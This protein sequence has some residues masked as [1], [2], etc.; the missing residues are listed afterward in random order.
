MSVA[1]PPGCASKLSEYQ[2]DVRNLLLVKNANKRKKLLHKGRLAIIDFLAQF[3]PQTKH[4]LNSFSLDVPFA[5]PQA[6]NSGQR[7]L[8]GPITIAGV[9][10]QSSIKPKE[11]QQTTEAAS[12]DTFRHFNRSII[13]VPKGNGFVIVNDILLVTIPTQHQIKVSCQI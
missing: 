7:G 12:E 10:S 13:L 8:I 5:A 3:F 2:G 6:A 4:N 9:F 1:F 11:F